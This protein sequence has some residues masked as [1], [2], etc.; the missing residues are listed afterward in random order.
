[1]NNTPESKIANE[2]EVESDT[3]KDATIARLTAER[4]AWEDKAREISS[5]TETA[6]SVVPLIEAIAT[7]REM[8]QS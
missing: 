8:G 6:V 5:Y 7:V 4:D 1:M 2:R 3:E